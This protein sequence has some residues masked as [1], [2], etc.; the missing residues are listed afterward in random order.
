MIRSRRK[1]NWRR[2]FVVPALVP[3]IILDLGIIGILHTRD[4]TCKIETLIKYT[5]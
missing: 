4:T 5:S 1:R 3:V 2:N